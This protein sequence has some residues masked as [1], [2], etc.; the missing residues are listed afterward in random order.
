MLKEFELLRKLISN[1]PFLELLGVEL[2][3]AGPGWVRERLPIRPALLQPGVV[4]GGAIS[5]LADTAT[6]HAVLTLIYPAEWT[7]T[8][9]Q[10]I[11]FLRPVSAGTIVCN[12]KVVQLGKRIA[13]CEADVMNDSG[14][15]VAKSSATL[16]RLSP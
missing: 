9:E 13:F 1:Q 6:A 4:H 2:V 3:D 14:E 5:S 16:M 10:K 12:A 11:N 7:T 15:L 8:V